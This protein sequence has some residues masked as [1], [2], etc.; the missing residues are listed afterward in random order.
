MESSMW[1]EMN[2]SENICYNSTKKFYPSILSGI[3]RLMNRHN[4]RAGIFRLQGEITRRHNER[5]ELAD[6]KKG[7]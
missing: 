3:R 5:W 2:H 6:G 1:N 4:V 7:C